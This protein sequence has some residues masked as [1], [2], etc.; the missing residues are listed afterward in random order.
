MSTAGRSGG[1]GKKKA[2]AGAVD[3]VRGEGARAGARVLSLFA[4]PLNAE[5]LRAHQEGPQR[6]AQLQ[7]TIRGSA[8]TTL[9]AALASLRDVGA[10]KTAQVASP[11][12]SV[13]TE[14][15]PTGKELLFVAAVVERWMAAAPEGPI[16]PGSR[17]AKVA[18]KSL[19]G[20]WSSAMMRA[21]AGQPLSLTEL[22][23]L[24]PD[25]SYSSLERR[26]GKMRGSRQIEPAPGGGRGT[27]Y[28]VTDWLR[29]SIAPLCAAGRCE[30]RRLPEQAP[31]ITPIE[32][33]AAFLLSIPL[34]R[35][36]RSLSG[37]CMLAVRTDGPET[38]DGKP[39]VAGV[40]VGVKAGEVVSC[41]AQVTEFPRSWALGSPSTWLDVV[42]DGG[43]EG[44]RFGGASPWLGADLAQGL[45]DALFGD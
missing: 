22:D 30:R 42:I 25:V 20:G 27:P 18:V 44:L 31:P 28:L 11:R 8:Q 45:H 15:T 37:T 29:R 26:L 35:L 39:P 2:A 5:I 1:R 23:G 17:A 33:E 9:R 16:A 21:L 7:E 6:L 41:A 34:V 36:Q 10:L 3:Q 40:T 38:E 4:N 13:A 19:A 43:L 24:I 14:L 32:V 12:P